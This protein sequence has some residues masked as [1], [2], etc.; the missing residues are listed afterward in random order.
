MDE[1]L[2]D[3]GIVKSLAADL[4]LRDVA[5]TVQYVQRHIFDAVPESGGFNSVRIA[6]LLHFR[7]SLPP[8]VTVAHVH[9]FLASPTRTEKE[10]AELAKAGTIR[11][12]VIPGRGTG[13]SSIGE[14]WTLEKDVERL[15]RE[16]ED[17]DQAIAGTCTL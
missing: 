4:S 12:L 7:K 11:R 13:G 2:E 14:G 17:L 15:V 8:T 5:Q 6:G 10:I 3:V 1:R 9:A 16:S